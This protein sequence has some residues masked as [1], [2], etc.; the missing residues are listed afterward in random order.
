MNA[1]ERIT[2]FHLG[3]QALIYIRQSSPHQVLTNQESLKLQ[4]ALR[5][6][7]QE[8]GWAA[9]AIEVIDADLGCTAST[10]EG[11]QGF[12][13]LVARVT[14]L[15]PSSLTNLLHFDG[16]VPGAT[17]GGRLLARPLSNVRFP[18]VSGPHTS[19]SAAGCYILQQP[20]QF[21]LCICSPTTLGRQP[22]SP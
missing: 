19:R 11:R 8:H 17:H 22:P 7:A 4:Y 14:L 3:R 15:R 16:A 10:T 1:S 13:D 9:A 21:F 6:R 2:P 5:R 18:P 20:G 12:K